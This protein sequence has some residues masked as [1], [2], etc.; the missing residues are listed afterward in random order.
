MTMN[1][2]TLIQDMIKEKK[3]YYAYKRRKEQLPAN[4]KLAVDALETYMFNFAKGGG[5]QVVLDDMLQLFEES[6]I[7]QIPVADIIGSDPVDFATTL[8]AQYPEELWIIKIQNKLRKEI[9]RI[10]KT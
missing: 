2:V 6:A 3:Q 5:F 10:E 4:Y 9:E 8:M 7:E 1:P